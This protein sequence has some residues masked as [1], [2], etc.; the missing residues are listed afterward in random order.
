[1]AAGRGEL[2]IKPAWVRLEFSFDIR[3]S[4]GAVIAL[5][6]G[7]RT[8]AVIDTLQCLGVASEQILT[9]GIVTP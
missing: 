6:S 1:M 3:A 8:R 7:Q 4:T 5:K 9:A 2:D